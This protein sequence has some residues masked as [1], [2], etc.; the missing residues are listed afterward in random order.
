MFKIIK[1]IFQNK[2]EIKDLKSQL[3]ALK[4]DLRHSL[5]ISEKYFPLMK[6]ADKV[7]LLILRRE[8]WTKRP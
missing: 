6:T 8:L 7:Q 1:S 3:S 4:F 2:K 5:E